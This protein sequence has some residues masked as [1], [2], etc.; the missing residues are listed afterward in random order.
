MIMEMLGQPKE[1]TKEE[2][3]ERT[4]NCYIKEM[5]AKEE[6][7]RKMKKDHQKEIDELIEKY[8][9]LERKYR[10]LKSRKKEV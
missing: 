7:I 9:T 10:R 2:K 6:R 5:S 8:E 3:L 1:E 4:L